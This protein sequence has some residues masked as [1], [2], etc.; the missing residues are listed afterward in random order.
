MIRQMLT[1]LLSNAV[2]FTP[3]GG[4]IAV[5][6]IATNDERMNLIVADTG[7]GIAQEDISKALSSFVQ[8][9][10]T[11]NRR[12]EGTGL[13]LPLVKSLVELHDGEL[14]IESEVGVGTSVSLSFPNERV[15]RSR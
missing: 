2:K 11:M 10:S 7:I 5:R 6:A 15:V 3:A 1:N 4:R 12:Y 14:E 8:I 9:E 13:G